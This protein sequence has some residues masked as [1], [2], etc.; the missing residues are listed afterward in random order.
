[1][2]PQEIRLSNR[3]NVMAIAII[4]RLITATVTDAGTTVTDI[5]MAVSVVVTVVQPAKPIVIKEI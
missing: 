2:T 1:M 5:S 4:A 3:T